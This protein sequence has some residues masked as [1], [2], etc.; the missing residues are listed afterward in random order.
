MTKEGEET[1]FASTP[2]W[3]FFTWKIPPPLLQLPSSWFCK[4]HLFFLVLLPVLSLMLSRDGKNFF[5][6]KVLTFM[7]FSFFF[8]FADVAP[9][10][11][12][13]L[14]L[15]HDRPCRLTNSYPVESLETGGTNQ[16]SSTGSNLGMGNNDV[17]H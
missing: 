8:P 3:S 2:N 13:R 1:V 16:Y 9:P 17:G 4:Y 5:V 11:Y 10:P 12:T 14:G 15:N 6:W 7:L